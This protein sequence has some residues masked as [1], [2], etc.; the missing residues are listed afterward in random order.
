[1]IHLAAVHGRSHKANACIFVLSRHEEEGPAMPHD[2]SVLSALIKPI[3]RRRFAASVERHQGDAYDKNFSSWQHLTALVFAQLSGAGSLR[4]LEAAWAANAQHQYHLG[5]GRIARSTLADAS[6]RRPAA[7]FAETF[8]DL[9]GLAGAKLRQ[10]GGE[11]VRLIDASP[12]PLNALHAMRAFN[13]RIKGAKLHLVYDPGADLPE[14]ADITPANIN[15]VSF[16]RSIAIRPGATYVFDK[17]YCSYPFWTD[18]HRAK[19][20]FVTRAKSNA[21]LEHVCPCGLDLETVLRSN[22]ESCEI[23]R[24]TGQKARRAGLDFFMRRITV[25]RENGTRLH[26]L[27]NDLVRP[28]R[29]IA[30]LYRR[31]WRIELL[32]RWI[33]QHLRIRRFLG[34]S[35]NAVKLQIFAALIAYI[36]LRLAAQAARRNDLQPIR[37][38]ELVGA[39][40]FTRKP[41][42]RI[43][44][45]PPRRQPTAPPDPRQMLLSLA[46]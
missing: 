40:L 39:A 3:S 22:V 38:S 8:A 45:P 16:A 24:A 17:G 26:I 36:L 1:M 28:A 41:I 14:A 4:A 27:T 44:K 6:A 23:V 34:R 20:T 12:I 18:I 31:R 32:F 46:A 33:K 7:I 5:A 21:A 30:A 19:A 43:D 13:G 10:E 29:D 15:D 37:F 11:L 42:A 35:E 9:A 25:R 2:P